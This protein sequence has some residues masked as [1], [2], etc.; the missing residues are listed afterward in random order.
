VKPRLL[1]AESQDFSPTALQ[2]LQTAFEIELKDLNR[3]ELKKRIGDCE[4]LWVRLRTLLD[5]EMLDAAPNLKIIATNTT[6]LNH[7]DLELA[8]KRRITIISLRGETDFLRT[9]RATAELTLG[10]TLACLRRIPLAHV[11]VLEGQWNRTPFK[12]SEIFDKRVGIIG[13]GRLGSITAQL[14]SAFGAHVSVSDPRLADQ[15]IVDGFAIQS[16]PE[17]FQTSEIISLHASYS[18][19]NERMISAREWSQARQGLVFVNTARGELVDERDMLEALESR[20]L[21]GLGLDVISHEHAESSTLRRLRELARLGLPVVLTPHI[22]GYTYESSARTEEFLARKL[23][24]SL[25][26]ESLS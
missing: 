15:T 5:R 16:L 18:V 11:S 24:E 3:A 7:L 2:L 22:G 4:V 8:E 17:L 20:R 21:G 25:T 23:V 14:F 6:G 9:V 13:Y 12:G 26:R 10:L 1:I 19:E